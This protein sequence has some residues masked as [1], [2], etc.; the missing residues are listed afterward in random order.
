MSLLV[1]LRR[2]ARA[3]PPIGRLL[4][5]ARPERL[6]LSDGEV[7]DLLGTAADDL[8]AAGIQVL[9]PSELLASVTLRPVVSTPAL[10]AVTPA[11]LTMEALLKSHATLE[12]D[13]LSDD[14]LAMLA[15]A[16]RPLIRLRGR[17][18]RA[19]P[20]RLAR[21][22]R[23]RKVGAGAA[24]AAALG[25]ELLVDGERVEAE[26][27]GPIAAL[28]D[29]LRS[30]GGERDRAEPEGLSATLRPYQ[31]RGLAWL[32]EMTELR[33]GG[34]LADDM[35]L[36]KTV[37]VLALHLTGDRRSPTLVV[38]PATLLGNWEREAGR[39]APG[40]PVRRFH[41]TARSLDD[42]ADDEIVL[43]TYGVARRDA[44]ALSEVAWG[45]VV[46]DEA[47][48]I[49]NPLARTARA[50]R[51]IPSGARFA[52][53]GTPVENRLTELWAIL[54]WTTPGLLGPLETFRREVAVPV[55]RHRDPVAT[56]SLARLVR[57]FLLR[58]RKSDPTI[59]PELP[60]KTETDRIV[61]L[62]VEQ[63]TLY[64]AV[65]DETMAKIR[66]T[67]GINRR[68]LV[69]KLLN[70]LKQICNHPAQ[71]LDQIGPL[72]GRSG[73]LAA[74]VDLLE[75]IRSENESALVFTQYVAMGRLLV[76]HLDGLGMR[77]QFLHGSLPVRRRE[78]MVDRFQTG[79]TDAFII[80][81]KAGG[82]GLNL[83]QATHVIHYDRW[84]NPA[85]EDQ[86]SD[87]AW[88][89]GQDRPV[90]VHRMVCEGT[91]ED[92]I[93]TMLETKRELAEAVVGGGEGWITELGDDDLA[94]LVALSAEAG[95]G[96]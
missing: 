15:E 86:A 30:F 23:R 35:G 54:D 58:R 11:G 90:Q 51:T 29:R 9:W 72:H 95:S 44:A 49:K 13:D 10:S 53:T 79:G 89:I 94:E 17:W 70:A 47:Q 21:L 39:F 62:T 7:D 61:P 83:T 25:G 19:D 56:E 1:A 91:V 16:K 76:E 59:A 69:L 88:R 81:L 65:V 37:Q 12:G 45:L 43:A 42:L 67:D 71:Y 96:A 20:E 34:V 46:A 84:W 3:W 75:V 85:V 93:A 82:T 38:C 63:A 57:P 78:E 26:V 52:L 8:G 24:L 5:E 74:A 68:G 33:L 41:G 64:K 18:V 27:T 36:G 48:A 87:R 80:S 60:P 55:E 50:M 6:E 28:G 14:E 77:T 22:G 2:G 66:D 92:R 31:R 4:E 32:E 73:K 40:V